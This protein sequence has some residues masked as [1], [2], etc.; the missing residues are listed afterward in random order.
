MRLSRLAASIAAVALAFL[1]AS[2]FAAERV[3]RSVIRILGNDAGY[4]EARYA[5]DG[6]VRV[7][8]E[9]NDRGR[10][11]KSDSTYRVAP[12]GSWDEAAIAG[13]AYLKTPVEEHFARSDEST[14]WKNGSE[15][16]TRKG[17]VPG[18]Y[19]SLDGPPEELVLIVRA[20]LSAG[21]EGDLLPVGH[22]RVEQV[23]TRD[24]KAKDGTAA[25]ATLYA[26]SGGDLTPMYLWL[27]DDRRFL[28]SYSDWQQMVR[29]G[30]EDALP[31]LGAAQSEVDAKLV[32]DRARKLTHRLA[33][34]LVIDDVRVFD[35]D[36]LA[37]REHQRVVVR[38][39]RIAAVGAMAATTAPA[40]AET[41]AGGG[42]FLMP[43]LWDMHVHIGG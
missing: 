29:E 40:G 10:G 21:G 19:S 20:L 3:E 9:F 36:T 34:P 5:D 15:D 25:K 1:T 24:V 16:E 7:H 30:F 43:G 8:Y 37:I 2:A 28:A 33:K 12:D 18:I 31:A 6:T 27:D 32:V 11:P 14:H 38:D 22:F 41:I 17:R 23:A 26:I 13:V 35:P 4:Q 39:G 42:Q